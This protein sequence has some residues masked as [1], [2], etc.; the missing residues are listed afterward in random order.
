MGIVSKK[1]RAKGLKQVCVL[2][3][4]AGSFSIYAQQ[5]PQF[6]QYMYNTMSVNPAYAGTN[7]HITALLM[8]RSQW[9]G[10][11][12]APNT[13]VLAV[14]SPLENKLG[15]G[16]IIARDA[17]GPS[18][19]I[20]LDGNVSY[21]I[22]LDSA[23][24]KLSF[25]MKVGG[26]IFD[27]DFSKGL[28]EEADVAFQNNIKSKF[29]PTIG[30]G[31]Y[32]D[33]GKGYLGFAIPSFF[34]QKHYDGEEQ[35]IAAE[36][37]HYYFIGGKVFDLT[38]DVKLKPGFFVKW[39]PG[40]PIIADVSVNA[41]LKETFTFG[42]AYRWDD[43]FSTLLGMQI[44]P[45]FSAGYAYDLTTSNLASYTGGSH[46]LFVRYE[47]KSSQKQKETPTF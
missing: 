2:L 28:T 18:S 1:Y 20:S 11:K 29:F 12:G 6:T 42:L 35:E 16:G 45:N 34:S 33:S 47:F 25:G 24:R 39:V 4:V 30:A 14:D 19:E 22:Q 21:T 36:R 23:N 5:D 43:S 46:E 7:G 8:H 37:L 9:V 44:D 3:V 41:L 40:A 17:L 31:I 15:I 26:R 27:V 38:P 13:Q 32:Y 10:V